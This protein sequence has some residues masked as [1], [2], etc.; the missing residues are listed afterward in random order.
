MSVHDKQARILNGKQLFFQWQQASKHSRAALSR[1]IPLPTVQM[2]PT[3][4][5]MQPAVQVLL[6]TIIRNTSDVLFY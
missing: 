1:D 4:P 5:P 6:Q 2:T 3:Y